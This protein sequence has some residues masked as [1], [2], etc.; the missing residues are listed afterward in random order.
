[1]LYFT[2]HK[3]DVKNWGTLKIARVV[4]I[5]DDIWGVFSRLEHPEWKGLFS[6]VSGE[7]LSNALYGYINQFIIEAGDLPSLK[8]SRVH[9]QWRCSSYTKNN[10]GMRQEICYPGSGS[11]PQCYKYP[12]DPELIEPITQLLDYVKDGYYLVVVKGSG[13]SLKKTNVPE[14]TVVNP[15]K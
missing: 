1:M 8:L 5:E 10:C 14:N 6:L 4:P 15:L 7:S 12:S 9:T 3:K 13:F 2:E 11:V